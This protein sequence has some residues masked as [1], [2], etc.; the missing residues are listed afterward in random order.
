MSGQKPQPKQPTVLD[1]MNNLFAGYK[2]YITSY[3]N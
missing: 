1:S 2:G 3:A